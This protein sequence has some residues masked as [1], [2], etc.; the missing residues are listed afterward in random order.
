MTRSFVDILLVC[1]RLCGYMVCLCFIIGP[2]QPS[3]G[4]HRRYGFVLSIGKCL[5]HLFLISSC[6]ETVRE[7]W[8][9]FTSYV[10]SC[11]PLTLLIT[12]LETGDSNIPAYAF[13]LRL[14]ATVSCPSIKRIL[15]YR[16]GYMFFSRFTLLYLFCIL[17]SQERLALGFPVLRHSQALQTESFTFP[18]MG[19]DHF[20]LNT[21]FYLSL[22]YFY[23]TI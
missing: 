23:W 13:A 5:P 10:A 20:L 7:Y 8:R 3:R 19:D 21:L 1:S 14:M 16:L 2:S 17:A 11:H 22:H 4:L 9:D 15:L 12:H 6:V 18:L